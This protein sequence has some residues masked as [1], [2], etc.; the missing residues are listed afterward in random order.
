MAWLRTEAS[1]AAGVRRA[2]RRRPSGLLGEVAQG[3][4]GD[5]PR[6][7]ELASSPPTWRASSP[8]RRRA[9]LRAIRRSPTERGEGVPGAAPLGRSGRRRGG[10]AK[11]RT[12]Q[13]DARRRRRAGGGRLER[14]F[15]CRAGD[16]AARGL[17][18]VAAGGGAAGVRAQERARRGGA[19]GAR[20]LADGHPR[21]HPASLGSRRRRGAGGRAPRADRGRADAGGG[22]HAAVR[23]PLRT[24]QAGV[25]KMAQVPGAPHR[26]GGEIDHPLAAGDHGVRGGVS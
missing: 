1:F 11:C 20:G 8:R 18:A 24:R 23:E 19:L 25:A 4:A 15:F 12:C 26:R 17:R 9:A 16:R 14:A 13:P 2:L 5:Q 21:R 6:A 22:G 10:A 3:A 7:R